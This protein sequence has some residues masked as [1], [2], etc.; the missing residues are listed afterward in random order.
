M[1]GHGDGRQRVGSTGK[2]IL[3]FNIVM[4]IICLLFVSLINAQMELTTSSVDARRGF[5]VLL[6][7]DSFA[8]AFGFYSRLSSYLFEHP[9]G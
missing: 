1:K 3:A 2:L 7:S 8:F 9:L 5:S 6:T 4:P